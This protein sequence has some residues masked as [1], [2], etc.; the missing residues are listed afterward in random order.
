MPFKA[1]SVLVISLLIS[2]CVTTSAGN[3]TSGGGEPLS[4]DQ[5]ALRNYASTYAAQGALLGAVAGAGLGLLLS[6]GDARGAMVGAAGGALVGGGAGHMIGQQQAGHAEQAGSIAA[7]KA[8]YDTKV[9]D[10]KNVVNASRNLVNQYEQE[11]SALRRQ[12]SG[13]KAAQ[14][15]LQSKLEAAK[16][17]KELMEGSAAAIEKQLT[18]LNA[19]I[20]QQGSNAGVSALVKQ[21]D[22]LK[23]QLASLKGQITVIARA[24]Q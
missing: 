1:V 3:G 7:V 8:Q 21:R 19:Y 14:A 6:K 11:I 16:R 13:D 23:A 15:R 5:Q 24:V 22:E 10:A 12:A 18:E 17:D 9:T 4:S 20:A 2:G